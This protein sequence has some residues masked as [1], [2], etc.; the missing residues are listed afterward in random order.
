[1]WRNF[2]KRSYLGVYAQVVI[3]LVRIADASQRFPPKSQ[4]YLPTHLNRITYSFLFFSFLNRNLR[5]SSRRRPHP[6][7]PVL[8]QSKRGTRPIR[9]HPRFLR[10]G[11]RIPPHGR[12]VSFP[13]SRKDPGV[14]GYQA[15]GGGFQALVFDFAECDGE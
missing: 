14:P 13:S 15:T 7:H 6:H 8:Q 10:R 4:T 3:P 11:I 12:W 5:H 1:M 2:L 9:R